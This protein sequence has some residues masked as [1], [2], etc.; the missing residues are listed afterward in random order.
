MRS[1]RP[2]QSII[3]EN[4]LR[5]GGKSRESALS[6]ERTTP[7]RDDTS[8]TT[9]PACQQARPR[10]RQ[11]RQEAKDAVSPRTSRHTGSPQS[12]SDYRYSHVGCIEW[13]AYAARTRNARYT[14]CRVNVVVA[15]ATQ[16]CSPAPCL[17][18]P[19]N[20]ATHAA[21]NREM[22]LNVS[23]DQ[24]CHIVDCFSLLTAAV[25]AV[26]SRQCCI[27]G[28]P[29]SKDTTSLQS[30]LSPCYI[31]ISALFTKRSSGEIPVQSAASCRSS[32]C[33]VVGVS[34]S[35]PPT[36]LCLAVSLSCLS[37][38]S[39]CKSMMH[40]SVDNFFFLTCCFCM[41]VESKVLAFQL[42]STTLSPLIPS[43]RAKTREK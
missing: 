40:Y 8:S 22:G 16:Y 11:T 41:S 3:Y 39:S 15:M 20:G 14:V 5:S 12:D 37:V 18:Q 4:I 29:T 10:Q 34:D 13:L 32:V 38:L 31:W 9:H 19:I 27:E 33:S 2:V 43:D 36:S 26:R 42:R 1:S 24:Y 7:R 25:L 35:R 17:G 21:G 28:H 30:L 23:H 6:W